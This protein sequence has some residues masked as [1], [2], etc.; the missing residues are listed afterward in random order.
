MKNLSEEHE[1]EAHVDF[2]HLQF[3]LLERHKEAQPR[4]DIGQIQEHIERR[5]QQENQRDSIGVL[6]NLCR[7]VG[8]LNGGGLFNIK[9]IAFYRGLARQISILI[10]GLPNKRACAVEQFMRFEVFVLL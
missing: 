2:V 6:E 4:Y 5:Y 3:A 9:L 1:R 7:I 10:I 8:E